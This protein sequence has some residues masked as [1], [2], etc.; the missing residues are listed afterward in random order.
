[1]VGRGGGQGKDFRPQGYRPGRIPTILG[2]Y[3]MHVSAGRG[4]ECDSRGLHAA[5]CGLEVVHAQE[6]PYSARELVADDRA[7]RVAIGAGEQDAG[8]RRT[9]PWSI[10]SFSYA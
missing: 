4:D 2:S 10:G 5:V 1:M 3:Q 8:L 6:E 7:L 9:L